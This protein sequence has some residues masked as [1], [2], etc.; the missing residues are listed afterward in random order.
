MESLLSMTTPFIAWPSIGLLHYTI[1]TA[2]RIAAVEG[3]AAPVVTYGSKVK[4]HGTCGGIQVW[5]KDGVSHVCAQS[6]T[7]IITPEDDY[8]G[9]AKWVDANRENFRRCRH[10]EHLTIFGEWCGLGIEPGMAV[11]AMPNPVFA[12]FALQVGVAE[13]ARCVFEPE[14]IL[15]YLSPAVRDC[16]GLHVL[17]WEKWGLTLD[18]QSDKDLAEGAKYASSAVAEVEAEDPWVKRVFGLSGLG[19]GLVFY[20]CCAGTV[21]TTPEGYCSYMWKAKGDKHRTTRAKTPAQVSP[22]VAAGVQ[23][24]VDLV[25][26]EARLKQGAA[27]CGGSRDPKLTGTFLA[28]VEADVKKESFLE[29]QAAGLAWDSVLKAVKSRARVWYLNKS[30]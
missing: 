9:F 7:N 23:E 18:F 26:T 11:S 17:P 22:D 16:P 21:P 1:E 27:A 10:E 4:Q 20:P 2:R 24:F 14:E 29:L 6:R 15:E 5:N 30:E 3:T 8:K 19:E 13:N 28:W 12:V 25:V